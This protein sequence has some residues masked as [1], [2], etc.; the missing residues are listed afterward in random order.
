MGMTFGTAKIKTLALKVLIV[1]ILLKHVIFLVV[2]TTGNEV[3]TMEL[4][5][6]C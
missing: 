2:K 3:P 6:C 4:E 1:M 5:D